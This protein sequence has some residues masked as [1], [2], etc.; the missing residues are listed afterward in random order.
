[1]VHTLD[2]GKTRLT[3]L[4]EEGFII[5][6][7]D[8]EDSIVVGRSDKLVDVWQQIYDRK[9]QYECECMQNQRELEL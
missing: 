9:K 4:D 3:K 6:F 5:R 1:M 7:N 2:I 8:G